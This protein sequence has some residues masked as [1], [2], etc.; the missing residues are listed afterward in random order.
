MKHRGPTI[1]AVREIGK[2]FGHEVSFLPPYHPELNPIEIVWAVLKNHV[3]ARANR[4]MSELKQKAL[5]GMRNQVSEKTWLGAYKKS[6]G[7]EEKY[8]DADVVGAGE[9]DNLAEDED[10]DDE[11]E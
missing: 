4:T 5:D 6:R 8:V 9:R 11:E 1:Y 2:E 10:I 3:G 7:W